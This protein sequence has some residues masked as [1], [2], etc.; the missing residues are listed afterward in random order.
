[1]RLYKDSFCISPISSEH[2]PKFLTFS[3][4]DKTA[5]FTSNTRSA[6]HRDAQKTKMKTQHFKL[7]Q[8]FHRKKWL[9]VK[10]SKTKFSKH[11]KCMTNDHQFVFSDIS[12]ILYMSMWT[13]QNTHTKTDDPSYIL[14]LL[15]FFYLILVM[16]A[17]DFR[18]NRRACRCSVFTCSLL[19][20]SGDW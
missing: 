5:H 18:V 12:V 2:I 14:F 13:K 10:L 3:W 8:K 9:A 16:D 1:M 17:I 4:N 11:T 15:L 20:S 19:P 7:C 6:L